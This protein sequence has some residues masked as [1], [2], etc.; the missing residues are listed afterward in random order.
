MPQETFPGLK[1][2]PS[3]RSS[4]KRP[5]WIRGRGKGNGKMREGEGR[6][7]KGREGVKRKNP[8]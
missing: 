5:N 3:Q 6:E 8:N 1:I 7:G 2:S 4:H